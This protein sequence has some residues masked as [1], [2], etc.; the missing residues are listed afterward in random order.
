MAFFSSVAVFVIAV[1]IFVCIVV[2]VRGFG[3]IV[4]VSMVILSIPG[5][6]FLPF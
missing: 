4:L 6:L 2:W 5:L 3:A 1:V